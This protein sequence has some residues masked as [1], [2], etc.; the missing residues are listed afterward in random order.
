MSKL[1]KMSGW[2]TE[3]WDRL[4][5][6][7]PGL[8]R[9]QMA[10][11]AAVGVASV[12]LVEFAFAAV[13]HAGQM[14]TIISMLLGAVVTMMGMM[15]LNGPSFWPKVRIA[16]FFPVAIG[17]GLL[18][19]VLVSGHTT[20]MLVMFVVV[21]F[22]AVVVRQYGIPF[23]FYGFMGWMGY[24]FATFTHAT[25]GMIPKLIAA[26]IVATIWVLLL[27]STLMRTNT[28]KTLRRTVF[29]FGSRARTMIRSCADILLLSDEKQR[30]RAMRTLRAKQIKLSEA[31][32]MVEGWSAEPGAIPQDQSAPLLRRRL[33]DVQHVLERMAD[34]TKVLIESD[35]TVVH[36][37]AHIAERLARRDDDGI[38]KDVQNL[39]HLSEEVTRKENDPGDDSRRHLAVRQF[40]EAVLEFVALAKQV[41]AGK[42]GRAHV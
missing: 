14:G 36:A 25:L 28:K 8:T 1:Q 26:I 22:A 24:F 39:I 21:M 10:G 15:A 3:I 35:E 12:L 37:A 9:L 23:F 27:S 4:A 38:E 20:L 34:A 29:A 41:S 11:S 42:I 5:A 6:S 7:D 2:L 33:I 16:V 30:E 17:I 19:G 31:A 18:C 32:L 40:S 13:T